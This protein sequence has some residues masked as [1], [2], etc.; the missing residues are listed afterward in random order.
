MNQTYEIIRGTLILLVILAVTG[1]I[2]F[3]WL[4][5]SKD[6]PGVLIVKWIVTIPLVVLALLSVK[7]FSV[8]GPF[9]IVF[10]AVI[11]SFMWTPNLASAL[12]RPLTSAI[13]GGSEEPE[14]RPFYSIARAKRMKGNYSEAL[15]EVR[16]QLDKF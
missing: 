11:L 4:K 1:W 10:C 13:D 14:P 8:V 2:L 9:V 15:A 7:L 6:D 5:R 3:R 12:V 16:K